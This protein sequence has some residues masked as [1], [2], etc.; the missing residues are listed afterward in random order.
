MAHDGAMMPSLGNPQQLG[1]WKN[2]L[3]LEVS[4]LTHG[5]RFR[6]VLHPKRAIKQ[7]NNVNLEFMFEDSIL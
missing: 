4:N 1:D 5:A 3:G 7:G 6:P 2:G